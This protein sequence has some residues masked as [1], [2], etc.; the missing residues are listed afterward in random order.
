MSTPTP[1]TTTRPDNGGR[2]GTRWPGP[3]A[4]ITPTASSAPRSQRMSTKSSQP[5]R[6]TYKLADVIRQVQEEKH[7]IV[8]EGDDGEEF[9]IQPPELWDDDTIA[10]VST[11][12][13][14]VK[15]ALAVMGDEDYARFREA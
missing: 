13:D 2:S 14:P 10:V 9:V 1:T 3:A 7:L 15:I 12:Q 5:P 6:K 11:A 8:I 4:D